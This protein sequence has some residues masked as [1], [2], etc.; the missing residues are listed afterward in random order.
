M[1]VVTLENGTKRVNCNHCKS[2]FAKGETGTTSQYQRHLASCLQRQLNS[3]FQNKITQ[4]VLSFSEGQTDVGS[5]G[6]ILLFAVE[7]CFGF[8]DTTLKK[9]NNDDKGNF[10]DL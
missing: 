2:L 10:E 8:F 1:E 4:Q 6:K 7:F 3:E 5:F 9:T